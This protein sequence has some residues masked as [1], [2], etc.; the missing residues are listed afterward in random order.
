MMLGFATLNQTEYD[1]TLRRIEQE[2]SSRTDYHLLDNN[3]ETFANRVTG[4][5]SES[6]QTKEWTGFFAVVGILAL[7]ASAG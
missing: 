2:V 7:I 6:S 4:G 5:V 1:A 3:C